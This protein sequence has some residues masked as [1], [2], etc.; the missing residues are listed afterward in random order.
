MIRPPLWLH[1]LALCIYAVLVSLGLFFFE[2]YV[3]PLPL[4][5]NII[6]S[7]VLGMLGG[8]IWITFWKQ[9]AINSLVKIVTSTKDIEVEF[10]D[11]ACPDCGS[12]WFNPGPR[13]GMAHNIRCALCGAKFWYSPPFTPMRLT[14]SEDKYYDLNTVSRLSEFN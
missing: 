4:F 9:R 12:V 8:Q 7:L 2:W 6:I 1:A 14:D 5:G 13:G 3:V 10:K 11:D